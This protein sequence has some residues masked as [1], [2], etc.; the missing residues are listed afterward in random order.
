MKIV[1]FMRQLVAKGMSWEDAAEMAERFEQGIEEAVASVI[2]VRSPA[3]LRQA[4]Y[5]ER[6]RNA[7]HNADH[8][9][10]D[11]KRDVTPSHVRSAQV[12]IPSLP[13][14]RSEEVG[15]G[16]GE[17]ASANSTFP[18]D[19]WPAGKATDHVR[20]LVS[21]VASPR[22]DPAK[23]PGLV[24]TAGRLVAWKREGASWEHDVVP[25]VTALCAKQ[26]GPV[27]TWKFFDQAIARSIADN[28]AALEIPEAGSVRATGPPNFADKLAAEKAEARRLA[29]AMMEAEDGRTNGNH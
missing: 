8:N 18:L 19:D 4:A 5:R 26:R 13:S 6:K 11:N 10:V 27:S 25:V 28:R 24:T 14:L 15:G 2:P 1:A 7:E 12:V 23:S 16:G 3:A 17:C 9:S 29:L 20:L 22:L 21:T